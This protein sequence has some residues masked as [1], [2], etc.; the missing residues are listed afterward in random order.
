MGVIKALHGAISNT[1]ANQWKEYFY[2]DS[3]PGDTLM[4]RGYK[5]TGSRSANHGDDDIISDGSI[6]AVADGQAA[7][8]VR[9]GK[10]ID[11]CTE[12]G[13]HVF[14]SGDA[15]SIF[16]G[17]SV[18]SFV[19]AVGESFAYGGDRP[20]IVHRVYYI[21]MK[22]IMGC[23]FHAASPIPFRVTSDV[24]SMDLDC[25]LMCGGAFTYRIADPA[26]VYKCLTGSASGWNSAALLGQ[27][28]AEMQSILMEAAGRFSGTG[29]RPSTLP[30]AVPLLEQAV[31][32]EF[33]ARLREKRGIEICELALS[34]LS[35]TDRDGATIANIQEASMLRSPVLAAM[36]GHTAE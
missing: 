2:A 9:N 26:A 16:G 22:E 14:E 27:M 29:L 1:A 13:E 8:V 30:S 15:P 3:L 32:D 17:S 19:R 7:I 20:P 6:I 21:N 5:R 36:L 35:L 12:P 33:N 23:V 24:N 10:V 11:V 28:K 18:G 34:S 31:R 4:C 25:G